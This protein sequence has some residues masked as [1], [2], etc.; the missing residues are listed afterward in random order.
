MKDIILPSLNKASKNKFDF[1]I[2]DIKDIP[3]A[4]ECIANFYFTNSEV[5]IP[6]EDFIFYPERIFEYL[7]ANVILL[8]D[9]EEI[10]F[11]ISGSQYVFLFK[12]NS[13]EIDVYYANRYKTVTVVK[14]GVEVEE[15]V[16]QNAV[17]KLFY[18]GN[19]DDFI[20]H[21][22]K[23]GLDLQNI[24]NNSESKLRSINGLR[25]A[26]PL[27][28]D[29][30]DKRSGK[31]KK[32]P[33]KIEKREPVSKEERRLIK[34]KEKQ[35]FELLKKVGRSNEMKQRSGTLF[36]VRDKYFVSID[37]FF[38]GKKDTIEYRAS[39]KNLEYDN[40]LWDILG[41]ESNKNRPLSLHAT[42]AFT[43]RRGISLAENDF[44]VVP[45]GD[46]PEE[47][48]NDILITIKKQESDFNENLDEKIIR[49]IEEDGDDSPTTK[50]VI[51]IHM[52]QYEK[53][54]ELAV[55]CIKNHVDGDFGDIN[56][57]FFEIGLEYMN[58]NN[59]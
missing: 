37:C 39:L 12:K 53:A 49:E 43:I 7:I 42:G 4:G 11:H 55:Q 2:A 50:F 32:K 36:Y 47:I 8:K 15:N 44:V 27:L 9:N 17:R 41:M 1:Y 18:H 30:M 26:I 45:L 19:F 20:K 13:N 48:I 38:S 59:L 5:I 16:K 35:Y 28:E 29:F 57:S 52:K 10:E 34:E 54:R 22:Y 40:I 6:S 51:Y 23:L 21:I 25:R 3:K 31:P 46:K 14:C 56:K 33:V 58:K 24:I